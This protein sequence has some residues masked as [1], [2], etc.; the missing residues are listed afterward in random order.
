MTSSK[1]E[2]HECHKFLKNKGLDTAR[3]K[4][5]LP[6]FSSKTLRY[7]Q[8]D[9]QDVT[10]QVDTAGDTA[11]DTSG[12]TSG[13]TGRV[14]VGDTGRVTVGDTGRVAIFTDGNCKNNGRRGAKGGYAVF[15]TDDTD[16]PFYKYN[17]VKM[18]EE[19]P[20]NQK[21]ELSAIFTVYKIL[22]KHPDAFSNQKIMICTD[23]LYSIN[24]ITKW[25]D[26]WKNNNWRTAKG[27]PVKNVELIQA[28][29]KERD[30]CPYDVD[31]KHVFSH[32]KQPSDK[33]SQAYYYWHGNYTVDKMINEMLE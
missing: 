23:S 9:L 17:T 20:T 18:M 16:S 3:I 6:L 2:Q 25:S 30:R 1:E 32:T 5:L 8:R 29:L 12:D 28:I 4:D 14:T 21:C 33:N 7:I 22:N 19:S 11:G 10:V 13:D 27:E 26:N 24:C 31:F 15:F